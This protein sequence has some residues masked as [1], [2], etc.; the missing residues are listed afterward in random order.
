MLTSLH[1]HAG[2]PVAPHDVATAWSIDP[3]IL[4]I[5]MAVAIAYRRGSQRSALAER[6]KRCFWVGIAVV[7]V[8]LVSPL[9]G[10]AGALAS[11]HMVQHMLLVVVAAPLLAWSRP[12]STLLQAEPIRWRKATGR[13]RRKVRL[14]PS[15]LEW[16]THP[17]LAWL[18]LA[19]SLWVWHSSYL[20]GMA[21]RVEAV[22]GLEHMI[23][24]VAGVWFWSAVL[25]G[26][27]TPRHSLG[28]SIL[29]LF[30]MGIQG[31]L[32]SVML[33]F[34]DRPWYD[35]YLATAPLWG[36]TALEDQ[37]LA[38]LIMWIPG[39]LIYTGAALAILARWIGDQEP[40][41]RRS[42]AP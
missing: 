24:L 41:P 26:M 36:M 40:V 28:P 22:H 9:D 5:V 32:L 37:H 14:T 35:E 39:G 16:L 29:L 34:S 7:L 1:P 12:I 4:G 25:K 13:W 3:L 2:R 20:Y 18:A 11:V 27:W 17:F 6:G 38:G 31:V 19:A 10:V 33:T 23:F 8:A 30:T 21:L 42:H 15:R